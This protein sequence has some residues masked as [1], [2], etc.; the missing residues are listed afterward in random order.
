MGASTNCDHGAGYWNNTAVFITW[1]DWGGWFDHVPPFTNLNQTNCNQW[2]C[3]YVYG[4]RVPLLVVSAYTPAGYVSG[5]LPPYGNGRDAIHTH[6]FGSILAFIENNFGLPIGSIGPT[7][8][9]FADAFAPDSFKGNI[10][11]SDFFPPNPQPQTFVPITIPAGYGASY[12]QNYFVN[13]PSET[14]DG[15][16]ADDADD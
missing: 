9:P 4:F 5:A 8:Y 13:N 1:D 7:Q 6:D 14:P 16:D 3:N 10:P 12:F 15:P 2:G 11:L